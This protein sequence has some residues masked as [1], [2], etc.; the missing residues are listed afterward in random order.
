MS[1]D[2]KSIGGIPSR[3][4]D[5]KASVDVGQAIVAT[6][7]TRAFVDGRDV[8]DRPFRSYNTTRP[9]WML[10]NDRPRPRG[11]KLSRT[12]RTMRFDSYADYKRR[13][14][15]NRKVNMTKSSRLLRSYRYKRRTLGNTKVNLIKSGRLLRSYRVKRASSTELVVGPSGDAIIYGNA[16]QTRGRRW[17]GLSPDDQQR[18]AQAVGR[19]VAGAMG[20]SVRQR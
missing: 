16:L 9:V 4:W 8:T 1:V 3:V 19:A 11:G 14:L 20:R 10:V 2:I 6:I 15:G 13:T 5:R 17:N 18:I 7:T 12:K